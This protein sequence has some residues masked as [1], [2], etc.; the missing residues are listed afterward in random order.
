VIGYKPAVLARLDPRT[1]R[2]LPGPRIRLRYGISGYGWSPDR[3][4]LVLGDVDDDA[5]HVVDPVRLRLMATI[6]F[7]IVA[8]APQAFAWL[9]PRR[10]AVVAGDSGD[11]STLLLVDPVAGRVL[12]RRPLPPA[13]LSVVAAGDRLVLLSSPLDWIGPVRLLVVDRSGRIRSVELPGIRAGF[14]NPPDWDR[15]GAYGVG[16]DAGLAVDPQGGR[17]F[18]VAAG[19]PVAEVDLASL[20][21]TSRHLRQPA[22]LLRRLAHWLVPP[23]EA[24]LDAGTRRSACWLGG[25]ILAVWGAEASVT[26]DTPATQRVD[27]RL[28][29]LKLIDTRSWRVRTL[30]PAAEEASWQAGR[31]LVYGGTWD[32][33]AERTRGAGLTLYGPGSRPPRHLL[34][35][36]A[37][38]EAHLNGDLVYAAVDTGDEQFGRRVVSLGSGGCSRPR[39]RRCPGCCWA[40]AARPAE[41]GQALFSAALG[42]AAELPPS[43]PPPPSDDD[44]LAVVSAG[45]FAL[46]PPPSVL[47]GLPRDSVQAYS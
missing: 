39:R 22:S 38:M 14:Q 43:D 37:V 9:G 42:L 23:A 24:K 4:L 34:G 47:A 46:S 7:G 26:G 30:D 36:E 17:A 33:R 18:V 15:P 45:F 32:A 19:V 11:G 35:A 5:L 8:E 16:R 27:R 10:L 28:T 20:Q 25:G 2:P 13:G 31:L 21:V 1:L 40:S 3:S 6:K 12:S 44:V 41:V 29:G